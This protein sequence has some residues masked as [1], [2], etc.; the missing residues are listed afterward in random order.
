MPQ[1]VFVK[2]IEQLNSS[3]FVLIGIFIVSLWVMYKMGGIVKTFC[4]HEDKIDELSKN[5]EKTFEKIVRF[6]AKIDLIYQ[7]LNPNSAVRAMSPVSLT[8]IGNEIA[9]SINAQNILSRCSDFLEKELEKEHPK[10]AYDI[11]MVSMKIAKEKRR[12]MDNV[13]IS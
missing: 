4:I 11:Q 12:R 9:T 13:D 8:P 1:T 6:E 3:V 5:S 10:N 2:I 7:Q